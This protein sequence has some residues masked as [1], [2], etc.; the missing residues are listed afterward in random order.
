MA[1]RTIQSLLNEVQTRLAEAPGTLDARQAIAKVAADH[2]TQVANKIDRSRPSKEA[3]QLAAHQ[4]MG[5]LFQ[6]LGDAQKAKEQFAKGLSVAQE[7]VHNSDSSRHNLAQMLRDMGQISMS[8]DRDMAASLNYYQEAIKVRKDILEHPN[9]GAGTLRTPFSVKMDLAEDSHASVQ[10]SIDWVM[11]PRPSPIFRRRWTCTIS[12]S[13]PIS[14]VLTSAACLSCSDGNDIIGPCRRISRS[15]VA[16]G[17]M[18]FYLGDKQTGRQ[19]YREALGMLDEMLREHP[20]DIKLKH[21]IARISGNCGELQDDD[22]AARKLL[23]R[24]QN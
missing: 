9:A 14:R 8:A 16:V 1:L 22:L 2:L 17:E 15:L 10:P 7:L 6:Q 24:G 12:W 5:S 11:S 3:T 13:K 23:E 19:R 20:K 21:E 18:T 4:L